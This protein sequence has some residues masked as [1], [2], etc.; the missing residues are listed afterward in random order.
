MHLGARTRVPPN[1]GQLAPLFY[2]QPLM[3]LKSVGKLFDKTF[4]RVDLSDVS[5]SLDSD[6]EFLDRSR[7]EMI[8]VLVSG[9]QWGWRYPH[10]PQWLAGQQGDLS[11]PF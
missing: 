11:S 4:L 8:R 5:S 10:L 3:S 6:P 1:L 9:S 2:I 7:L